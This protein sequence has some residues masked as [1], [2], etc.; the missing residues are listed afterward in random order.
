MN[1]KRRLKSLVGLATQDERREHVPI[2]DG[3]A[4]TTE[5]GGGKLDYDTLT[6]D[7]EE[8]SRFDDIVG[9]VVNHLEDRRTAVGRIG[10]YKVNL[11]LAPETHN[12]KTTYK[13]KT[14]VVAEDVIPTGN[15]EGVATYYEQG[16]DIEFSHRKP[17]DELF[18]ELVERYNFSEG[19]DSGE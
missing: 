3:G 17:A 9:R 12:R 10:D 4:T 5:S 16:G 15:G 13:L 14:S 1:V 8:V 18:D 7:P 6:P 19:T 11:S 2:P